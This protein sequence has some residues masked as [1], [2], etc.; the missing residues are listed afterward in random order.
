MRVAVPNTCPGPL[1]AGFACRGFEDSPLGFV[2]LSG[3]APGVDAH[4]DIY[5][6]GCPF[7]EAAIL[8]NEAVT[9]PE[10]RLATRGGNLSRLWPAI[11]RRGELRPVVV[12]NG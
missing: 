10:D 8:M 6:V 7:G 4:Q 11:P 2:L 1:G 5:G 12:Q 9:L 3:D